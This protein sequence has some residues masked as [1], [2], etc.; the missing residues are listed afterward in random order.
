MTIAPKTGVVWCRMLAWSVTY[1]YKWAAKKSKCLMVRG[2]AQ[3]PGREDEKIVPS[4]MKK[5]L[6]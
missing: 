2:G 6:E 1:M 5:E 3:G 4:H